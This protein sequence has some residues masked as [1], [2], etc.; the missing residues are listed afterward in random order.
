[1]IKFRNQQADEETK[2]NLVSCITIHFEIYNNCLINMMLL[3]CMRN[4][5][6]RLYSIKSNK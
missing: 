6:T 2:K 5:T 3:I 1:M 4:Q